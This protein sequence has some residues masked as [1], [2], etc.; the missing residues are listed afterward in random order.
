MCVLK[1]MFLLRKDIIVIS[2]FLIG[3]IKHSIN[4]NYLGTFKNIENFETNKIYFF[5][6]TYI[7]TSVI[8]STRMYYVSICKWLHSVI[9]VFLRK[10]LDIYILFMLW[11][12]PT[13][14]LLSFSSL[15]TIF[16][17]TYF[18]HHCTEV[19]MPCIICSLFLS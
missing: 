17:W 10:T 11:F 1:W 9:S 16:P 4:L 7:L 19:S 6:K 2:I 18:F 13:T 5:K 14:N 8:L 12:L 15:L 3:L